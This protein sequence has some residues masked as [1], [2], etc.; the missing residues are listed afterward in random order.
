MFHNLPD[1]LQKRMQE[2][3]AQ[4]RRD[5]V[6]GTPHLERLR[7][8]PSETGRFVAL[9]LACAPRGQVLEIGTSGG[10]SSLWLSLACRMR[11]D[12]LTTFEILP[13]KARL[14]EETFRLTGV[15]E[16]IHL[17]CG[18]AR[19]HLAK[20]ELVAF[21]FM[22]AEKEIYQDCYDLVLPNLVPGGL[23]LADN[24]ISHA[25][26]LLDFTEHALKDQRV[27]A[28]VVPIGKGVFVCRKI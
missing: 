15:V 5:R 16:H 24:A 10:Y 19:Q 6:D 20:F 27:D 9:I 17:V 14:A 2:M 21:C 4:D 13:S 25:D 22:D 18:D 26:E 3:E 11:D 1:A 12:L 7:Q 28:L 8:I 23:L